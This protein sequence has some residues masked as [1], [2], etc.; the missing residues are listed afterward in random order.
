MKKKLVS[1]LLA[2]LFLTSSVPVSQALAEGVSTR[3][4]T[5]VRASISSSGRISGVGSS[6]N[7][8]KT[9]TVTLYRQSGSSWVYVTSASKTQTAITV[10]A[11][12]TATLIDGAYYKAVAT[13][14]ND[15]MSSPIAHT[16]YYSN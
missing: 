12:T 1:L 3:A 8:E 13:C 7:E 9:V 5:N 16:V 2:L 10:T 6:V 11:S 14:K 15:S 4:T